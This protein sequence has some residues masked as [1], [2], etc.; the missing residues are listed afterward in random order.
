M[1]QDNPLP[2]T[3]EQLVIDI[4]GDKQNALVRRDMT[5]KALVESI[6]QAFNSELNPNQTYMLKY[7]GSELYPTLT[8]DQIQFGTSK[9]LEFGYQTVSP[10]PVQTGRINR[11]ELLAQMGLENR[12]ASLREMQ[13]GQQFVLEGFP[14]VVGRPNPSEAHA[15]VIDLRD[16]PEGRSVSREHAR[17]SHTQDGYFITSLKD[18]NPIAINGRVVEP[19]DGKQKLED[20]DK[21]RMGK[22]TLIFNYRTV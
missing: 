11:N 14:T 20:G 15:F 5:I 10:S 19:G 13:T 9:I 8:I 17:I 2:E 1:L 3:H 22:V 16:L 4:F 18:N 12:T 7:N 21:I 6:R